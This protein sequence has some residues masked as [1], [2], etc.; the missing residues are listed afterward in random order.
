MTMRMKDLRM[1][2]MN[3]IIMIDKVLCGQI[4]RCGISVD[5]RVDIDV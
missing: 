4:L 3:G 5:N 1:I 2:R